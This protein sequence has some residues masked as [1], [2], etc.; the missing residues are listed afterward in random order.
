[1]K[2]FQ[3]LLRLLSACA[4]YFVLSILMISCEGKKEREV[5]VFSKTASFRHES[6]EVGIQAIMKLGKENGF[7]VVQ[8]EDAAVFSEDSLSRYQAVVFLNTT[9][10]VLDY[11]QQAD[12]ERYI[13][14]GGGYVG[15]HAAS[16]TEYEWP[17]YGKL[18]GAFFEGH[19]RIQDADM[20]VVDSSHIS[21]RGME[22]KWTF[23]E[24]W[25]S[26]KAFDPSIRVLIELDEKSYYG[27]TNGD[28]HPI[29]WYHDFDGGRA[30]YTGLG[31]KEETFADNT[32]LKVLLGGIQY[33]MGDKPL[34]YSLATSE[35]IPPDNRFVKEV[36]DFNLNEPM[37]LDELPGKGILFIERNGTIKLFD[38]KE[39]V[40]RVIAKK[41]VFHGNEDGLLG[42][43][44]D[45]DYEK[46][47]WIYLFY[48]APGEI[49]E[50]HISRFDLVDEV[51]DLQSEKL[52]LTI[53]T[54]REC[55]HSGGSLEFGPGGNLFITT[56]DNTNPFASSGYA[57]I[58]EREGRDLWDAQKSSANTNDLRGKILRIKPE[59][60][61]TYSI[62]EGNLF[63]VGTE[64]ARPEIYVMGCRNPFRAAIDSRTGYLYWG[65]VGPDAGKDSEERGPKGHDEYNQARVA[66]FWGWPYTRGD[67]QPYH[68]Y[69]FTTEKAGAAFDPAHLINDSPH[70]TGLKELPPAQ[71]SFVWYSYGKSEEFPWVGTGGRTAMAGTVFH[72][73]NFDQEVKTFPSYFEGKGIFYEWIRDKIYMITMDDDQNFV[74]AD[75][76]MSTTEFSHPIDMIFGSDGDLYVLEY[77][78][79]WNSQNLDARLSRVRYIW[80]N[81]TPVARLKTDKIVG[82]AP[83]TVNFS[84]GESEDYDGD[85]LQYKWSISGDTPELDGEEVAHT[86]TKPGDYQVTLTVTDPSGET[87]SASAMIVVGNDPP[88]L[89][90]EIT[91]N[92]TVYWDDK[93]ISYRVIVKDKEDGLSSDGSIAPEKVKVTFTYI[94][95]GEDLIEATMGHQQNI[96]PEGLRLINSSDCKACHAG[97][98][99]VN[100]PSYQDIAA[101][102][103]QSN[104][105]YL[106]GKIIKGGSGVW[107][108]TA[109][110]AHPQLAIGDVR[111]MVK[112]ILSQKAGP[113]K[114]VETLPLEGELKF[115]DHVGK[116]D[117]GMYV[118]MASYTDEGRDKDPATALS[119]MKSITFDAQKLE[120]EKA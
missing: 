92:D 5:L 34:D 32:F 71:K 70:N 77:G 110:A 114:V 117:V 43:A 79:K 112:Y 35:R 16:D 47:N 108:E 106:V 36:L 20:Y 103:E 63:P 46:N 2:Y 40:V 33:A 56:G 28:Y 75:P 87:S 6:I 19:S 93:K 84:A 100:G 73:E 15:V 95:Q 18:A 74:K 7:K 60:D 62:P 53:P 96:V 98:E 83:L 67:N 10:N 64:L 119:V 72:R 113:E 66:G 97:K 65:D 21:T 69:D 118:L 55:C 8:T 14:A 78:Q 82:A 88:A 1:M 37:E 39:G 57:P 50:Q 81:R 26:F 45:P 51:L 42:V 30:F 31:H 17:W 22:H 107:G 59:A 105:D 104:I 109:M 116:D 41:E 52:L 9:G 27:G 94:P 99:K 115:S 85:R 54:L 4:F 101:R 11:S 12:F 102:Y 48:S 89:A 68:D 3:L 111:E 24:E 90:I 120:A 58:D 44:I 29:T 61:G 49:S 38:Q 86:F 13:Q 91:P 76:F 23:N 25:Y 80:G